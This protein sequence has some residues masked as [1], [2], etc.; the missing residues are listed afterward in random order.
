MNS[1]KEILKLRFRVVC[2]VTDAH[3]GMQNE[4]HAHVTEWVHGWSGI[5]ERGMPACPAMR[6]R[7]RM[8]KLRDPLSLWSDLQVCCTLCARPVQFLYPFGPLRGAGSQGYRA[9]G[10]GAGMEDRGCEEAPWVRGPKRATGFHRRGQ[11]GRQGCRRCEGE[12]GTQN[13]RGSGRGE[14]SRLER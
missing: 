2:S 6:S 7:N 1:G 11:Q 12:A 14:R 5:I 9:Q 10:T 8:S 13:A 4:V 3:E